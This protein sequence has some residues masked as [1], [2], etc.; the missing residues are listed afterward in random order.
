VPYRRHDESHPTRLSATKLLLV[1]RSLWGA[2]LLSRPRRVGDALGLELADAA[3]G[4][5]VVRLLGG[6]HL[7]QALVT[8][9][10]P[11]GGVVALGAAVDGLHALTAL[12]WGVVDRSHRRAGLTD[13]GLAASFGVAGA[14]VAR[15]ALAA[16]RQAQNHGRTSS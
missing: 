3:P 4:R 14:L 7:A 13:A 8:A 12:G 15:N 11:T 9:A 2:V 10:R 6:R 5:G 1:V 16:D